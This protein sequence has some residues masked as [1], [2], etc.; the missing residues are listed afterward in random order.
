MS[1]EGSLMFL[2]RFQR[3]KN[4]KGHTYWALVE[5]YRTAKGSR[6]RVIAY[7]GELS[8]DEQDGWSK[9]GAHLDGKPQGQTVQRSL[10][11]PPQ[12]NAP[13]DDEPVLVKLSS[14]RAGTPAWTSATCGWRGGCGGCWVS[15]CFSIT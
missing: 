7:L 13:S 12:R 1:S 3:R 2:R 6:Q 8:S 10:F 4:G 5:S 9:L 14:I 15:T 11:D